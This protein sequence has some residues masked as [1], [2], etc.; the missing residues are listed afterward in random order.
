[1][2]RIN[3]CFERIFG[4]V[5]KSAE[6]KTRN[7]VLG[8]RTGCNSLLT[9]PASELEALSG[10]PDAICINF[11]LWLEA[12]IIFI[13]RPAPVS[14]IYGNIGVGYYREENIRVF[15]LAIKALSSTEMQ[16]LKQWNN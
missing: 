10:E 7:G 16:Q 6:L 11:R 9:L 8:D 12:Y 5:I 14:T 1:M 15:S 2:T 4:P 3:G 13:L